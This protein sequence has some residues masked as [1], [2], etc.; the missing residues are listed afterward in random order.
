MC[1]TEV[2]PSSLAVIQSDLRE[3]PD[4]VKSAPTIVLTFL[5]LLFAAPAPPGST[6]PADAIVRGTKNPSASSHKMDNS[7][8]R[9]GCGEVKPRCR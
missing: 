1:H 5:P 9:Q 8:S 6:I 7:L 3:E 2:R 4:I